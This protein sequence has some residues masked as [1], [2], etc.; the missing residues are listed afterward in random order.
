MLDQTKLNF[1]RFLSAIMLVGL[2]GM[3]SVMYVS[4]HGGDVTLIHA[5]VNNRNG[6]VRIVG[7][8]ATCDTS[9]ETA[10]DWGIQGPKGDKG[11]TGDVGPMGPV[12]PQGS[13]GTGTSFY[14]RYASFTVPHGQNGYRE[15]FGSASC[16]IGDQVISG[17]GGGGGY[18]GGTTVLESTVSGYDP[19]TQRQYWGITVYNNGS[20]D[21]ILGVFAICADTAP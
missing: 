20:F 13:A 8:S 19:N 2:F 21:Q 15:N 4:A 10:L 7:A 11:D 14:T 12:G 18:G 6:A 9:K 1:Y 16:D 5:C 17:G 3:S